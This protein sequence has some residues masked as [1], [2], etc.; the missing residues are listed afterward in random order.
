MSQYPEFIP[1]SGPTAGKYSCKPAEF[2][3]CGFFPGSMYALL[4]RCMKYPKYLSPPSCGKIAFQSQLL[5]LS[6]AWSEPLHRMAARTNTH[7]LGFIIQPA[8]RMDWEL[9]GNPRSFESVIKAAHSLS[10]RYDERLDAVRSWDRMINRNESITD[11]EENF[12][13]I[14]DS[15]CSKFRLPLPLPE[16]RSS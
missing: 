9:T 5:R 2:W 12:L 3:T 14:I 11:K 1:S 8:L 7:D 13:V 4:E 16:I 10:L 15:M 6:R